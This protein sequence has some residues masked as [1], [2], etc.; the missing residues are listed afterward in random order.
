MIA[1]VVCFKMKPFANGKNHT[2]NL[3]ELIT[4]LEILKTIPVVR[5]MSVELNKP[6]SEYAAVLTELFD[7]KK[8]L[9]VYDNHPTHIGI[10]DYIGV[11]CDHM[12]ITDHEF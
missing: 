5:S 8:A 11:V 6:G 10:K 4:R 9:D 2:Q 12:L 7:D 1:H 3:K